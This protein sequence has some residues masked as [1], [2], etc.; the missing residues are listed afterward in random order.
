M[1]LLVGFDLVVCL[2][3]V[4]NDGISALEAF[5]GKKVVLATVGR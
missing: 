4:P 2:S 1:S 5:D 3:K